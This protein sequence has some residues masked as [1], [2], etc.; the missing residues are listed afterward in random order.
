MPRTT[1]GRTTA[2]TSHTPQAHVPC[3]TTMAY[4]AVDVQPTHHSHLAFHLICQKFFHRQDV[5][6]ARIYGR[7]LP[8]PRCRLPIRIRT[9]S[10]LLCTAAAKTLTT[11]A[12]DA[13]HLGANIGV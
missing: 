5:I 9:R 11:I 10:A 1:S 13:K 6:I 8:L 3:T 2:T 12:A 4:A 7:Y